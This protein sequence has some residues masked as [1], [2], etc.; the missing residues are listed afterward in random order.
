MKRIAQFL[1]DIRLESKRET[2]KFIFETGCEM[3]PFLLE[4]LQIAADTSTVYGVKSP[5]KYEA[6]DSA[7]NKIDPKKKCIEHHWRDIKA[8]LS[9]FS[10]RKVTGNAAKELLKQTLDEYQPHDAVIIGK[11]IDHTLR[12]GFS[13]K[14]VKTFEVALAEKFE[15]YKGTLDDSWFISRKLDGV[16]CI[17]MIGR[18]SVTYF[19][20][21]GKEYTQFSK[22]TPGLLKFFP[23]GTVL[24][25]EMC[26]V[27]KNG[28]EDFKAVVSEARQKNHTIEKPCYQVFDMLL[29]SEFTSF[30]GRR[31]SERLRALRGVCKKIE[32]SEFK[33][34]IIMLEQTVFS[35]EALDALTEKAHSLKWEGLMLR[36][37]T[38]YESGRSFNLLKLKS[39]S[40]EEFRVTDVLIGDMNTVIPGQ[41]T[42]RLYSVCTALVISHKGCAVRVGSGLSKEQRIRWGQYPHE[43]M[44]CLITVKY[45]EESSNKKGGSSLRFPVLRAFH[46]KEREV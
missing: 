7:L 19:S 43:A 30:T 35:P 33:K 42:V 15:K 40:E 22:I 21:S 3:Y 41:G 39:F 20:R 11:I 38:R 34:S 14:K 2:K 46:G 24:D 1:N 36:K 16:R 45:F 27:N 29:E 25:G 6:P 23:A 12:I 37:D 8:M 31:L 4:L 32:V 17:A 28:K 26:I 18:T 5:L 44:N 13:M 10:K 9:L